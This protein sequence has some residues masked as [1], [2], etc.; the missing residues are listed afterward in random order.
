MLK[1]FIVSIL[2]EYA[3]R[4]G[5]SQLGSHIFDKIRDN[6]PLR[7]VLEEAAKNSQTIFSSRIITY[8]QQSPGYRNAD[9]KYLIAASYNFYLEYL[10]MHNKQIDQYQEMDIIGFFDL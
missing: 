2:V 4:N 8:L 1:S 7:I 6:H 5:Q 10:K 9:K 3:Q